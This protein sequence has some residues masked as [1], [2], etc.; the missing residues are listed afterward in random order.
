MLPAGM[1]AGIMSS[2]VGFRSSDQRCEPGMIVVAPF[3]G[4]KLSRD[5]IVPCV[6]LDISIYSCAD[7]N[8]VL[9]C[10]SEASALVTRSAHR[11]YEC[12]VPRPQA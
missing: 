12:F 8:E 11:Q 6:K 3:S 7:E 9:Q 4:V 1:I 10:P 2:R 5:T